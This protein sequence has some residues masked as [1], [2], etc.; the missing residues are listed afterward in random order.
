MTFRMTVLDMTS[1]VFG[2]EI[3][4]KTHRFIFRLRKPSA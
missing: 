3:R 4:G 1:M 2:P